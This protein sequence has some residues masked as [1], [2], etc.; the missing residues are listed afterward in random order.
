MDKAE[1]FRNLTALERAI[2]KHRAAN[3]YIPATET[4]RALGCLKSLKNYI[5]AHFPDLEPVE[6][7]EH[8]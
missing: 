6:S 1:H 4:M 3:H 7:E 5:V 2:R 8:H